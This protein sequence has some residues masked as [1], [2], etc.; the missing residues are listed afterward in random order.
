MGDLQTNI[1]SI[2][3]QTIT[4]IHRIEAEVKRTADRYLI[5]ETEEGKRYILSVSTLTKP[6]PNDL[7]V[8]EEAAKGGAF[9]I[10]E[11]LIRRRGEALGPQEDVAVK[12]ISK[13]NGNG[14]EPEET[15]DDGEEP[16][17][18]Q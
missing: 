3:G 13:Q 2:L 11:A 6:C 18:N 7:L 9:T 10:E 1:D 4:R 16:A 8:L 14:E 17:G 5:F 15:D 12:A